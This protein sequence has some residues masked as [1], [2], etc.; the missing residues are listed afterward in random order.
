MKG[1]LDHRVDQAGELII[2]CVGA[3]Y[4]RLT[5]DEKSNVFNAIPSVMR[6]AL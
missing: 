1:I 6:R 4:P 5:E 2:G 3:R